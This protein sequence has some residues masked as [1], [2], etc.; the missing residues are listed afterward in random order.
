[1]ATWSA[2][3]EPDQHRAIFSRPTEYHLEAHHSSTISPVPGQPE[4]GRRLWA[5]LSGITESAARKT[6]DAGLV[7]GL[8]VTRSNTTGQQDITSFSIR[9]GTNFHHRYF[10]KPTTSIPGP[11]GVHHGYQCRKTTASYVTVKTG[12]LSNPVTTGTK[13]RQFC[14]A[15]IACPPMHHPVFLDKYPDA[16]P[17]L[18]MRLSEE[19]R[20][21]SLSPAG[22]TEL[23]NPLSPRFR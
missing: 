23:V 18:Y 21:W 9:S 10:G 7:G 1:M 13:N 4:H 19:H 16:M 6:S 12:D 20:A 14:D 11:K 5:R 17:I 3:V 2:A 22:Q 8:T 15:A